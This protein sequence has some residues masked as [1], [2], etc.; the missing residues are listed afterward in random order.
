MNEAFIPKSPLFES[1]F[2]S[3]KPLGTTSWQPPS[4]CGGRKAVIDAEIWMGPSGHL[5]QTTSDL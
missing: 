1:N 5:G 3:I 2:C 4:V